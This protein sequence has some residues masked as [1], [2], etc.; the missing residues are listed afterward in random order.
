M[1][2][3]YKAI[4]KDYPVS[5]DDPVVNLLFGEYIEKIKAEAYAKGIAE[6]FAKG[7]AEGFA[8]GKA[9]GFAKGKAEGFAEGVAKLLHS[10]KLTPEEIAEDLEMPLEQVLAI[11][12]GA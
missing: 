9:E 12:D 6:G 3:I 2:S 10:G 5:P 7:K 1:I 11:R 4:L 8:K